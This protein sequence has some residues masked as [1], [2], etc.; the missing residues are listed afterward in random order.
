[1]LLKLL[2]ICDSNFPIGSFSHSFGLETY[3]NEKKVFDKKSFEC[4][5]QGYMNQLLF[6]DILSI[7][8]LYMYKE[9]TLLEFAYKLSE[10][11]H[12]S[13]LAKET[14][15]ANT[16]IAKRMLKNL[17]DLYEIKV[18]NEYAKQV[19]I[20]QSSI[21]YG[22][23]CLYEGIDLK[24][25][26]LTYCFSAVN[27]IIQNAIRAIPLSQKDGQ[28]ILKNCDIEKM[29]ESVLSLEIEDLG[30]SLVG[31]EIAQMKHENLEFRLFMS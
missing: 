1:M 21:V 23:F 2:Q 14:K 3:I 26:I 17:N 29:Y 12:V 22:L 19:D 7:K 20:P 31:L 6:N 11:L 13:T 4:W 18:L 30:A 5:L 15:E 25:S 24:T 16:L 9:D 28:M 8:L 27:T 10:L